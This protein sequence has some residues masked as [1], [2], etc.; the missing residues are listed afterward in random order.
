MIIDH[1]AQC[2]KEK[3]RVYNDKRYNPDISITILENA[4]AISRLNDSESI[5]IEDISEAIKGSEFLNK[6]FRNET[7]EKLKSKYYSA[8]PNNSTEH[9]QCK[10]IEFRPLRK[11]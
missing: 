5:T 2:T 9:G 3:H 8:I 10:V 4:F 1:I 6:N 11:K 7:A